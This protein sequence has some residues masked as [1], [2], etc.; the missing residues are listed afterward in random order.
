MPA[1]GPRPITEGR[2]MYEIGRGCRAQHSVTCATGPT[3][4][5]G[6]ERGDQHTCTM[7]TCVGSHGHDPYSG[8]HDGDGRRW[9]GRGRM[10]AQ[11]HQRGPGLDRS[12]VL[13]HLLGLLR[14]T[15]GQATWRIRLV[16]RL[17]DLNGLRPDGLRGRTRGHGRSWPAHRRA[18]NNVGSTAAHT[19]RG[20]IGCTP[21]TH[22]HT[23]RRGHIRTAPAPRASPAVTIERSRSAAAKGTTRSNPTT[24]RCRG[25]RCWLR[26]V[27]ASRAP[28]WPTAS[29]SACLA[30]SRS[31]SASASRR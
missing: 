29:P 4:P 12:R 3:A 10:V 17:E 15:L 8:G 27:R 28:P 9:R 30:E 2:S 25:G 31:R 18:A 21:T 13:P 26:R 22:T 1:G 7:R 14:L 16:Q 23:C 24:H 11:H 5:G 19:C 6:N 20:C